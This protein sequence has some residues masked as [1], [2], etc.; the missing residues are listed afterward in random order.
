M[1]HR[2]AKK[3]C[4]IR[5]CMVYVECGRVKNVLLQSNCILEAF[6]NSKTR[7]TAM[8]TRVRFGKYMD[9]NFDFKGEPIGGHVN[10]YLLEKVRHLVALPFCEPSNPSKMFFYICFQPILYPP[11]PKYP[12][13]HCNNL[14]ML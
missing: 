2:I 3:N 14:T 9:I 12:P 10:N 11:P 13:P 8:T 4:K 6:G 1:G 5:V 7:I